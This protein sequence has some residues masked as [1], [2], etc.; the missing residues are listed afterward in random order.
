MPA[1]L[2]RDLRGALFLPCITLAVVGW[3]AL[4]WWTVLGRGR[5]LR[6][7]PLLELFRRGWRGAPA[8]CPACAALQASGGGRMGS[9]SGDRAGSPPMPAATPVREGT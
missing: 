4:L 8:Q 2:G 1:T 6:L 9:V 5:P 3:T 7:A